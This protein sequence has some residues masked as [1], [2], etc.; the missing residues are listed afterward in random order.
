MQGTTFR[1]VSAQAIQEVMP[2]LV[3]QNGEYLAVNYAGLTAACVGPSTKATPRLRP[4]KP[5][6]LMT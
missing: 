2:E 1:G 6:V 5:K 4:C 3:A